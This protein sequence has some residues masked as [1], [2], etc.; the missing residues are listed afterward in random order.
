MLKFIR[1]K[2]YDLHNSVSWMRQNYRN[3][4]LE[5][6]YYLRIESED[7]GIIW[8]FGLDMLNLRKDY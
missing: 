6:G 1:P 5:K 3:I 2:K 4:N 7:K 8:E